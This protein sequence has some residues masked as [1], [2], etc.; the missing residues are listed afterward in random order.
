M[1]YNNKLIYNIMNLPVIFRTG[2]MQIRDFLCGGERR[3]Y[4]A[5]RGI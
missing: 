1:P 3:G 4:P 5:V 2:G